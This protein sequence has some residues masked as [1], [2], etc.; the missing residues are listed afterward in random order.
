L[1]QDVGEA[2]GLAGVALEGALEQAQGAQVGVHRGRR[3]VALAQPAGKGSLLLLGAA[4]GLRQA[5][6][7]VLDAGVGNRKD[8][9]VSGGNCRVLRFSAVLP[10]SSVESGMPHSRWPTSAIRS[11]KAWSSALAAMARSP[12]SR[13]MTAALWG[14]SSL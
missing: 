5:D 2:E 12:P 7:A 8:L 9:P 11:M 14:R 13:Y 4:L 1:G 10:L 6:Q 3:Q